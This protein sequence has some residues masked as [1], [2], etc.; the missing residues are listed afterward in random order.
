MQHQWWLGWVQ[1]L[2]RSKPY[3]YCWI[4][5]RITVLSAL[6][7]LINVVVRFSE[8]ANSY[9][10]SSPWVLVGEQGMDFLL[11]FTFWWLKSKNIIR[12]LVCS[13]KSDTTNKWA[14]RVCKVFS[15]LALSC[16]CTS[17]YS[18]RSSVSCRWKPAKIRDLKIIL[19]DSI[20]K[21]G[22]AFFNETVPLGYAKFVAGHFLW[23]SFSKFDWSWRFGMAGLPLSK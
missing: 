2:F 16:M 23:T 5:V 21:R 19:R 6:S 17:L 10:L 18:Y 11:S 20:G 12:A 7:L 14:Q 15:S 4:T 13:W 3:D 22:T 9:I 8:W 1:E